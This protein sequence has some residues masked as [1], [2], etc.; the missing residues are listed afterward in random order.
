MLKYIFLFLALVFCSVHPQR[1]Y[2]FS[3]TAPSKTEGAIAIN[4]TTTTTITNSEGKITSQVI[5]KCSFSC[6]LSLDVF[7]A[8]LDDYKQNPNS[9]G[10]IPLGNDVPAILVGNNDIATY[11]TQGNETTY[12][13]QP[14]SRKDVIFSNHIDTY[15]PNPC[16]Q[17]GNPKLILTRKNDHAGAFHKAAVAVKLFRENEIGDGFRFWIK[18]GGLPFQMGG[19]KVGGTGSSLEA[20]QNEDGKT[21]CKWIS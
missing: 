13:G 19:D 11:D 6:K 20:V 8:S 5:S 1:T 3:V 17:S 16:D 9:R 4:A 7:Y 2:S 15:S 12:N 18:C 21:E 14:V 10:N